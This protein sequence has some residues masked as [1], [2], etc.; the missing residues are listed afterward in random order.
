VNRRE[1]AS[2]ALVSLRGV[3]VGTTWQSPQVSGVITRGQD[4]AQR[5][6]SLQKH[7]EIALSL[8][9]L[10]LAMTSG[11][12]SLGLPPRCSAK[13]FELLYLLKT[14]QKC[15]PQGFKGMSE[16]SVVVGDG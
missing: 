3:P 16:I 9:D 2:A 8:R 5:V 1:T 14:A 15:E 10:F 7:G 11:H 4:K 6:A 12:I 13:R